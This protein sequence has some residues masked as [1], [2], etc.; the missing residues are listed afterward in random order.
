MKKLLLILFLFFSLT[1]IL[2]QALPLNVW[3]DNLTKQDDQ[4]SLRFGETINAIRKYPDPEQMKIMPQLEEKMK[5]AT[6]FGIARFNMIK[7]YILY[8]LYVRPPKYPYMKEL[9]QSMAIATDLNDDILMADICYWYSGAKQ[10]DDE[11]VQAMFYGLKSIELVE[12]KGTDKFYAVGHRYDILGNL[13]YHTREYKKSIEYSLKAVNN[14][15]EPVDKD[16]KASCYN[17]VGL[18]YKKLGNTDSALW[19]FDKTASL[20]LQQKQ[21]AWINIANA[22][23]AQ[24]L[25]AQKRYD[26]A[27]VFFEAD[28]SSS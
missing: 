12:K 27:R 7:A 15:V 2:G 5:A 3:V 24:I 14:T 17:T 21:D 22:N 23:K 4:Q 9:K 25:F 20:A 10:L 6:A 28:Y 26:E 16:N 18:C 11:V 8:G 13:L 19:W 1:K